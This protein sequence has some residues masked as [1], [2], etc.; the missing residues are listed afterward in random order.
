MASPNT[1]ALRAAQAGLVPHPIRLDREQA[2][3]SMARGDYQRLLRQAAAI[4]WRTRRERRT[5]L[6]KA[7][8]KARGF[9]RTV[10]TGGPARRRAKALRNQR[11]VETTA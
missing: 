11:A 2:P 5:A 7:N 9:Q 3:K 4:Y 6:V 8:D 1:R 10:P